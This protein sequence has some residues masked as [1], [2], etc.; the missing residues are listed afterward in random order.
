MNRSKNEIRE[1]RGKIGCII[2]ISIPLILFGGYY[3]W[4]MSAFKQLGESLKDVSEKSI[5]RKEIKRAKKE[6]DFIYKEL[7]VENRRG[8]FTGI[9]KVDEITFTNALQIQAVDSFSIKYR[10]ESLVNWKSKPNIE[11]LASLDS[12]SIGNKKWEIKDRE[13]NLKSA[14]RFI[15]DK[16][17]CQIEILISKEKL[18]R[19]ISIVKEICKTETKELTPMMNFK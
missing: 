8:N 14:F 2:A 6:T 13:G 5:K 1:R 3:L 18:N 17:D 15:D 11:G 4:I 19:S 12:E 10:I 16:K 9:K 7:L